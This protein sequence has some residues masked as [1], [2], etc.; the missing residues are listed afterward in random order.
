MHSW[1]NQQIQ[2]IPADQRQLVTTYDAFQ[3]YR[4]A[5]WDCAIAGT[6]IGISTEEQ[7]RDQTIQRLVESIKK[8]RVLAIFYQTTIHP[9]LIKTVAQ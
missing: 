2:T 5:Y 4:C 1:I 8:I 3:Y 6:L 9:A 7:P